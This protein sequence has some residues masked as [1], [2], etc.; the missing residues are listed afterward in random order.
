MRWRTLCAVGFLAAQATA[1]A[2]ADYV[3]PPPP[4]VVQ[5]LP[6]IGLNGWYLRG[7]VGYAWGR[8]DGADAA[9]GF[10]SPSDS[11]LG[12]AVTGGLGV[13]YKWSWL[14]TDV[15]FDY[16]APMDYSGSAVSSGDVTAKISAASALFNGYIDLG[17]WY[18]I[19]P[20]IG[21]GAGAAYVSTTDYAS[22]VA[23]PFTGGDH[24]QWNFAWAAMAGL[25]YA[26]TPQLKVDVGYRY[27]NVGDTQT[28]SDSFG[29]TTF[30]NVAAHEVRVGLRWSFDAFPAVP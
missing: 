13:G 25:D 14:R 30:K 27:L 11:A 3:P 9:P 10:P 19:T 17:T 12:N 6:V 24:H 2:A 7:D 16:L 26:V 20:Y 15:T 21:A 5:P 23:P 1:A 18:C 29:Q 8:I 22:T 4:P 28:E